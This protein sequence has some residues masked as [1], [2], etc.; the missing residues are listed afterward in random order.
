VDT[1]PTVMVFGHDGKIIY[2]ANGLDQDKFISSLT[3]AIQDAL[4]ATPTG[5]N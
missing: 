5:P 4:A 2:R 1:L 3:S